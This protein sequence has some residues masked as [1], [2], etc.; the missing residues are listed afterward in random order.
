MT[1]S[2]WIESGLSGTRSPSVMAIPF[3]DASTWSLRTRTVWS[4][5]EAV[6]PGEAD[7]RTGALNLGGAGTNLI[8][9]TNGN[10]NLANVTDSANANLTVGATGNVTLRQVTMDNGGALSATVDTDN[11]S[12]STL[13][14][15]AG[16]VQA[17]GVTLSGGG[18]G[19]GDTI[20][21][22]ANV[23]ATSGTLT[24][25]NA[26]SVLLGS[27]VNLSGARLRNANLNEANLNEANLSDADLSEA[28]LRGANL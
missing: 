15:L 11:N 10:V 25:Q 8:T 17:T 5:A 20:S 3:T 27:N 22:G 13:S 2:S 4:D 23:D 16:G 12:N 6:L 9:A 26:S 1:R 28:D 14:I 7:S 21:I 18:T 24:I 19:T